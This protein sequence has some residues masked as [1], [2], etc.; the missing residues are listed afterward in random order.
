MTREAHSIS[1]V[2]DSLPAGR[3]RIK[4]FSNIYLSYAKPNIVGSDTSGVSARVVFICSVGPTLDRMCL[5]SVS[6]LAP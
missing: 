3:W 6:E 4:M 2:A 5:M 1:K